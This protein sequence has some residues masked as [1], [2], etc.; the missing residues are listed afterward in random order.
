MNDKRIA[1]WLQAYSEKAKKIKPYVPEQR[2]LLRMKELPDILNMSRTN[3]Y[4]RIKE[5]NFPKPQKIGGMSVWKPEV[6]DEW[7]DKETSKA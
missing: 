2:K 1:L 6:V 4:N 3:I 7:I 5:G